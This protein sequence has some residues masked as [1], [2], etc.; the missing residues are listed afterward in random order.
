MSLRKIERL[1]GITTAFFTV[2]TTLFIIATANCLIA[3]AVNAICKMLNISLF[4]LF[5][6]SLTATICLGTLWLTTE[7]ILDKLYLKNLKYRIEEEKKKS[8]V[9]E[10][11]RT[12]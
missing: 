4:R 7:Y 1:Q 5:I 12:R 6:V 10:F 8:K 9:V 2:T 3:G 11:R